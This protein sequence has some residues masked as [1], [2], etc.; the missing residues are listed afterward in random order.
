MYFLFFFFFFFF[1]FFS[2][3]KEA[4][5][6]P[7]TSPA[8]ATR[9]T[10]TTPK[11]NRRKPV[12][13]TETD[14]RE[15]HSISIFR[16][17]PPLKSGSRSRTLSTGGNSLASPPS[18]RGKR[19]GRGRGGGGGGGG[20]RSRTRAVSPSPQMSSPSLLFPSPSRSPSSSISSSLSALL[21]GIGGE[22]DSSALLGRGRE[23]GEL[24]DGLWLLSISRDKNVCLVS[25]RQLTHIATFGPHPAPVI[26]F[27]LF[28]FYFFYYFIFIYLFIFFIF[29]FLW[30]T[31]FFFFF[32]EDQISW[33]PFNSWI[34]VCFML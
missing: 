6:A 26:I 24:V 2:T 7:T 21:S 10:T 34:F 9:R 23:E 28:F 16:S 18:E 25:L 14:K 29:F 27:F 13:A 15:R 1:F 4:K 11:E 3:D 20:T 33:N 30:L 22:D 8:Q 12:R 17:P 31:F 32:F 19:G 5:V